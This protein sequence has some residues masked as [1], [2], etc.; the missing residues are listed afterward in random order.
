[1][2]GRIQTKQM[3]KKD[4]LVLSEGMVESGIF[5]G[6]S[7]QSSNLV[8]DP[9]VQLCSICSSSATSST[10]LRSWTRTLCKVLELFSIGVRVYSSWDGP[11]FEHW[12]NIWA[13]P[14]PSMPAS[15][16][17]AVKVDWIELPARSD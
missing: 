3:K 9:C 10:N 7:E 15:V 6:G 5:G 17:H 2:S 4:V 12:Q 8:E 14:A 11:L 1:M 13:T 16:E